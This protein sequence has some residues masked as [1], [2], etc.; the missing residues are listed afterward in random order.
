M[1]IVVVVEDVDFRFVNAL[2]ILW[3]STAA[4]VGNENSSPEGTE[5]IEEREALEDDKTT[6]SAAFFGSFHSTSFRG[7]FRGTCGR[8][9]GGRIR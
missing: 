5:E 6:R 2:F 1:V 7:S 9:G 8:F 3:P 4:L